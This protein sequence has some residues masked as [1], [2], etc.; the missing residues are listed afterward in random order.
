MI[1][2]PPMVSSPTW[3]DLVRCAA[4]HAGV[5]QPD[6]ATVDAVL[7]EHTAFPFASFSYVHRQLVDLFTGRSRR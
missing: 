2:L 5:P 7:W 1:S 3:A 4:S 6:D